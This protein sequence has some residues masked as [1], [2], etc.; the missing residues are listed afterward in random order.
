G[1]SPGLSVLPYTKTLTRTRRSPVHDHDPVSLHPA[2]H[3]TLAHA[4]LA[5]SPQ[6]VDPGS[7]LFAA[8]S[9]SIRMEIGLFHLRDAISLRRSLLGSARTMTRS[10]GREPNP[11]SGLGLSLGPCLYRWWGFLHR[12]RLRKPRRLRPQNPAI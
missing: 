2:A 9:S 5:R 1:R 10:A 3:Q 11:S 4:R 8:L 7:R 12:R 6:A